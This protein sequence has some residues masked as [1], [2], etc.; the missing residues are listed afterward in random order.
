MQTETMTMTIF[1]NNNDITQ[2]E[3]AQFIDRDAVFGTTRTVT[4]VE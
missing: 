4:R 1:R 3:D 2:S